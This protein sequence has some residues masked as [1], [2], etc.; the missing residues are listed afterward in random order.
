M[1]SFVGAAIL[2]VGFLVLIKY[3]K[4][5]D[6][7]SKVLIIAK[8]SFAIVRDQEK[9][10][11]QKEIAMQKFAKELFLLFFVIMAGSLL[12]LAIPAAIVWLMDLSGLLSFYDVID[13][14]FSWEFIASSVIVS[15]LVIWLMSRKK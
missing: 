1:I 3:L 5:I 13:T 8:E 15:V 12:A 6:K 4:V 9:S 11:M 10:D 2:V 7:S 14:T